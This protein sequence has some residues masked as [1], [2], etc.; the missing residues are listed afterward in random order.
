MQQNNINKTSTY[1]NN[2]SVRPIRTSR[3]QSHLGR[4]TSPPITAEIGLACCMCYYLCSAHCRQVKSLCCWYTT[5]T[6][7]RRTHN[8]GIYH[9]SL[10]SHNKNTPNLNLANTY[11]KKQAVCPIAP[12]SPNSFVK[13]CVAT[14]HAKNG[15]AHFMCYYSPG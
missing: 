2:I 3:P 7:H 11:S 4:A 15:L 13:S 6:P 8:N 5:S 9:A 10:V 1:K 12:V 14:P